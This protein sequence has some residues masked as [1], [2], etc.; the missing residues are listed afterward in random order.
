MTIED[1]IAFLERVPTLSLLGRD[2][3]RI[4]AIGAESRHL[5]AGDILFTVD[6]VSDSG[7]VVQDG[8]ISLSAGA[9]EDAREMTVGRGT[10]LGEYALL[11]ET[12]RPATATAIEGTTVLRISRSLFLKTMEGFPEAARRLRDSLAQRTA[13]AAREISSVRS[14]LLPKGEID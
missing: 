8:A 4:L 7:F 9:E 6:D 3:L 1:D 13:E 11:A 10:L 2:A 14:A 5:H 12:R